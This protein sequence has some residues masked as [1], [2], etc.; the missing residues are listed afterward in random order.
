MSRR[1]SS[2]GVK[3]NVWVLPGATVT[4]RLTWMSPPF[5]D[6]TVADS[7]PL[8]VVVALFVTSAFRVNAAL[9]RSGASSCTTCA[10]LSANGPDVWSSIGN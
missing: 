3:V 10:L 1:G 7:S 8:C 6:R 9:E 2:L 4:V 5:G